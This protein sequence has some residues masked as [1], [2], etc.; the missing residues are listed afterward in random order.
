MYRIEKALNSEDFKQFFE[1]FNILLSS[2]P[3]VLQ[4]PREAYYHSL[5][6]A[7]LRCLNFEVASEVMTSRGRIDMVLSSKNKFFVFEFKIDSTSASALA[8]IKWYKYYQ[9]LASPERKTFLIGA[10]FD[11][12]TKVISDWTLEAI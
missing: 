1:E 4:I 12:K 7:I 5:L 10:N 6:Y 8:Q 9:K 3:Y 11:T 2:I